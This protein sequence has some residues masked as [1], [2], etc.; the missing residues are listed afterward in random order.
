MTWNVIYP[1]GMSCELEE[2]L[3]FTLLMELFYKCHISCMCQTSFKSSTLLDF[4]CCCSLPYSVCFE[5]LEVS[6]HKPSVSTFLAVCGVLVSPPRAFFTY[7]AMFI[8][9]DI[10]F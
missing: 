6:S 9:C 3:L 2:N 8:I 10:T 4:C 5:I 1:G 7:F